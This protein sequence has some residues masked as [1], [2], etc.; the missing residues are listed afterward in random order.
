MPRRKHIRSVEVQH[1]KNRATLHGVF[2]W[3]HANGKQLH[4]AG[5]GGGAGGAEKIKIV[6]VRENDS[7]KKAAARLVPSLARR[8]KS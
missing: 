6:M 3:L 1:W 7:G 2:R 5:S 4:E 8:P